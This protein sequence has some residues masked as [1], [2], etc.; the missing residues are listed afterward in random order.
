MWKF[1][2]LDANI[3]YTTETAMFFLFYAYK[4]TS[5]GYK[6]RYAKKKRFVSYLTK[7]DNRIWK[8]CTSATLKK[9]LINKTRQSEKKTKTIQPN[10]DKGDVRRSFFRFRIVSPHCHENFRLWNRKTVETGYFGPNTWMRH[11]ESEN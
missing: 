11:D 6:N 8:L 1:S 2:W 3:W 9:C 5:V 10:V 4:Y 7:K